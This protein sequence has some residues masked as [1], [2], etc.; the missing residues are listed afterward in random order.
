MARLAVVREQI[1][2]IERDR[3]ARLQQAPQSRSNAMVV[4]L[5]RVV[6]VGSPRIRI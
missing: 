5:A 6:G 4:L 2:A 1:E 3:L